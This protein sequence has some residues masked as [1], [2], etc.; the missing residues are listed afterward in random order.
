MEVCRRFVP[1]GK[2][3]FTVKKPNVKLEEVLTSKDDPE[4]RGILVVLVDRDTAGA[5][6]V[7][8]AVLRTHVKAMVIGQQTR[9][10]AVEFKDIPL[11]SGEICVSPWPK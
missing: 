2:V 6:E 10:E 7:I 4:F 5:A 8:A 3:L 1:K 11:Q 9:G